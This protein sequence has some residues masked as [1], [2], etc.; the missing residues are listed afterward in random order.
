MDASRSTAGSGGGG[1]PGRASCATCTLLSQAQA[2]DGYLDSYYQ[3][4]YP[5]TRFADLQWG[6]ELYCAGHLIQGAIAL[7]RSSGDSRLL[8]WPGVSRTSSCARSG[9][10]R[11]DR[12]DRRPPGDRVRAGGAVPGDRGTLLFGRRDVLRRSAWARAARPGRFG[13]HYWQDHIP[14]REATAERAC[15]PPALSVGRRG[16]PVYGLGTS[17]YSRRPSACGRRWCPPGPT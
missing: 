17:R 3:V 9:P 14:V 7:H 8:E 11:A 2:D 10:R 5:G 16:R 13:A 6:H 15:R 1:A 12:R 4:R